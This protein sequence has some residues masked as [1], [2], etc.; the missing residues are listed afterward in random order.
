[1]R[2]V[3][4]HRHTAHR[5]IPNQ[6]GASHYYLE[7]C[8]M[9]DRFL[10]SSV[11]FHDI[12]DLSSLDQIQDEDTV[13]CVLGP[14]AYLYAWHRQRTGRNYAI[15]RDVH[16]ALWE[17]YLLQERLYLPFEREQDRVLFPSFYA[18]DVHRKFFSV[19]G[20][21]KNCA[22]LYPFLETLPPTRKPARNGK[23]RIG[24]RLGYLGSLAEDKNLLDLLDAMPEVKRR[25]PEATFYF[26]GV[27]YSRSCRPESIRQRLC[28]AGF[29]DDEVCYGGILE[30]RD[31]PEFFSRIDLLLFLSTSSVETLGRVV[32]EGLHFNVP[33]VVADHG[34]MRELLPESHRVPVRYRHGETIPLTSAAPLGH[35][36]PAELIAAIGDAD[37]RRPEFSPEFKRY[38][39]GTFARWL[40]FPQAE[41]ADDSGL[42]LGFSWHCETSTRLPLSTTEDLF[43]LF[44]EIYGDHGANRESALN[45]VRDSVPASEYAHFA[46][47]LERGCDWMDLGSFPRIAWNLAGTAGASV[48]LE[49]E[50]LVES[51]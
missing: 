44:Y 16:T 39:Y 11:C 9:L 19:A 41:P 13:L 22:V 31:L 3:H 45:N 43:H 12:V 50:P 26:C 35:I 8:S 14:Y 21:E 30:R 48:Q 42:S 2:R 20:R 51:R 23:A 47:K 33:V 46:D 38:Q 27:P 6:D 49:P 5:A 32:L 7:V 37:S 34:A 24:M 40:D 1:V 25:W 4:V 10:G 28:A 29:A 17:G 18:R 15:I 36:D